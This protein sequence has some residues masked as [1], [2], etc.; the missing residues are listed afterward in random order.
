MRGTRD[1]SQSLDF[2]AKVLKI[3]I[4]P[5]VRVPVLLV[6]RLSENARRKRG[7]LPVRGRLNE[8]PF[9][10]TVV[11]FRGVWRLYLN[12]TMRRAA[13]VEVGEAARLRLA[14]DPRPRTYPMPAALRR[15]LAADPGRARKFSALVPSR[16]NEILRYLGSLKTRTSLKRN[17]EK[18]LH[19][20]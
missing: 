18:L 4:N 20:L 17:V 6:R 9:L 16:Q 11:K 10:Q 13:G 5:Y 3:G 7:P 14:F 2:S 1:R 19:R 12:T 15:A 8:A